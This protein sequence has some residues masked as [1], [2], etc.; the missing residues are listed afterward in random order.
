M[1]AFGSHLFYGPGKA[2]FDDHT[3]ALYE[4]AGFAPPPRTPSP[5]PSSPTCSATPSATR[6]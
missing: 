3:L 4:R 5:P 6:R 2:R 1:Q